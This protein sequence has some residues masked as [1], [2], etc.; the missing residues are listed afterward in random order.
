MK[1]QATKPPV[2]LFFFRPWL[3][4][5]TTTF[6]A[7]LYKAIEAAGYA[8]RI[9]RVKARGEE[10]TR[11]FAKYDGVEYQ[12]ITVEQARKWVKDSPTVMASPANSKYLVDPNLIR[13]LSKRG[14][15]IVMHDPNEFR[16]YDHLSKMGKNKEVDLTKVQKLPTRPICI[17]PTMQRFYPDA[18]WI[19]HPYMRSGPLPQ[20]KRDQH[21][22]SVAR[23]AA[24]K[25]PIM[26]L[27]ANRL[28]PAAK[29][30]RLM[31]AEFRM[32]T[33]ELEKRYSDVFRQSGKT[34]QY[35]M[36]F[37]APVALCS[38]ARFNVDFTWFPDDGGGTQYAQMEAMDAGCV[39]IM[40][41]DW[42]RYGGELKPGKHVLTAGG[43]EELSV[44]LKIDITEDERATI[45]R[46]CDKLLKAHAPD[47]VGK[48]YMAELNR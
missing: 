30:V 8:P 26:V 24:V 27:K 48:L 25:R 12:N 29:R 21:A 33:R 1:S 11:Q 2:G 15:R 22:I 32:Y 3:G 39:N 34:F 9:L 23:I 37:E 31:G 47:V 17:R 28:L 13:D 10:K 6:T 35:P 16:I 18:V 7:H 43:P 38:R 44:R 42:F 41:T 19:P 40:H 45:V 46:N 4:G 20:L 36:T 14:M 5:G